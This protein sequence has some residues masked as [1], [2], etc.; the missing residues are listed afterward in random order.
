MGFYSTSDS[1]GK[2]Q[3]VYLGVGAGGSEYCAV[4]CGRV[5]RRR[6]LSLLI[7]QRLGVRYA[8]RAG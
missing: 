3:L 5:S 1:C 8:L 2:I 7:N 6:V 4:G